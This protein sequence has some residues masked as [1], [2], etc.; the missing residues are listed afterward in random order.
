MSDDF[1][2]NWSHDCYVYELAYPES[3][4]GVTFYVGKGRY[5]R[6]NQ[7]ERDARNGVQSPVCNIIR[8]IWSYGEQIVKRKVLEGLD[9][10]EARVR[11][12][13]RIFSYGIS[14]LANR[15][16]GRQTGIVKDIRRNQPGDKEKAYN[17]LVEQFGEDNVFEVPV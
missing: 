4:G 13:E 3:M 6:I 5:D 1:L 12:R 2:Y 9:K 16:P 14:K 17:V 7:H 15:L 8:E 11:E 10:R